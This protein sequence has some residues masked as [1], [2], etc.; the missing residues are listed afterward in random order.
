MVSLIELVI[1]MW[2]VAVAA[3]APLGYFIYIFGK[4]DG[5][6]FGKT[7]PDAHKVEDSKYYDLI[8][9]A[10]QKILGSTGT[11]SPSKKVT[12][13]K[14]NTSPRTAASKTSSTAQ[15]EAPAPKPVISRGYGSTPVKR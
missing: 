10:M 15:S 2:V 4:G 8:N 5:S 12:P 9:N 11:S 14:S 7:D 6:T 13:A 1:G 3:F